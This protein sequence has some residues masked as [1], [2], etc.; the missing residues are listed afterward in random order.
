ML[1]F[2]TLVATLGAMLA[3]CGAGEP[4]PEE[5]PTPDEAALEAHDSEV[6]QRIKAGKA[7]VRNCGL[8]EN[9]G[10]EILVGKLQ[11]SFE[12][13]GDGKVGDVTVDENGTGSDAVA[14]CVSGVVQGWTFPV[15]PLDESVLFTYPFEV[16]PEF[17][18]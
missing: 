8:S 10:G 4:A 13:Q 6:S 1:R 14:T 7:D 16:G 2:L 9:T 12:I 17:G 5:P 11:V 15:H 18:S 3:G